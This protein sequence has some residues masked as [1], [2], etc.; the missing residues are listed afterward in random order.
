MET[1][2][3]RTMIIALA[4]AGACLVTAGSLW[5]SRSRNAARLAQVVVWAGYIVSLASV[6]LFIAAGFLSGR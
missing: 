1:L 5:R 2:T 6:T 4:I 3:D